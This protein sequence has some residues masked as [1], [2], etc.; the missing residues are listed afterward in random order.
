VN[1][2]SH[3]DHTDGNAWLHQ[4]GATIVAHRNSATRMR[5]TTRVIDWAFTD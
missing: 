4:N 2:Y 5:S 3:W 1:T